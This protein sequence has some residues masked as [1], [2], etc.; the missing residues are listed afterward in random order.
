[1]LSDRD[2]L[3]L[4]KTQEPLLQ[5]SFPNILFWKETICC[6]CCSTAKSCL[7]LL[8]PH[9]LQPTKLLDPWSFPGTITREGCHFLLQR[10]FLT[11]GSNPHLP[12][13]QVASLPLS[14]QG[15]PERDKIQ[16]KSKMV[17]QKLASLRCLN[18]SV[19]SHF[20][21]ILL[22]SPSP[23]RGKQGKITKNKSEILH[24]RRQD[25]RLRD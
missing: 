7:T 24:Q 17:V 21:I 11:Q 15:S 12:H 14:H 8:Q 1:M 4:Q 22:Y 19:Q 13:W 9:G 23:R 6:C 3:L 10:I 5:S 18:F 2:S 20:N 25:K 16:L